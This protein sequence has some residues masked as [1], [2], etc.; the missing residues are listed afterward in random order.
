MASLETHTELMSRINLEP[1]QPE[2]RLLE[3]VNNIGVIHI[4]GVSGKRLDWFEKWMGMVDYDDISEALSIAENDESIDKIVLSIDS[5]GGSSIGTQEVA[6]HI[7]SLSTPVYAF[8]DSYMA[9]AA[10]YMGSQARAIYATPTSIVGSIGTILIRRDES[11][12][13]ENL[14]IKITAIFQGKHKADGQP[15]KPI[16]KEE[17]KDL[18]SFIAEHHDQFK[19][20]VSRARKVNPEVFESKAYRSSTALEMGLID[21]MVNNLSEVLA[22]L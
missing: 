13:L 10:Y 3:R 19:A 14:G 20:T 12:M 8:T 15:F 11:K 16:S 22:L 9:S 6:D 7:H 18:E 21:G 4:N 5:P 1:K 17:K 2:A